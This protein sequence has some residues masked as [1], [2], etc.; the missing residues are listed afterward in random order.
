MQTAH[1]RAKVM[2]KIYFLV[3]YMPIWRCWSE[4][5][6]LEPS[7]VELTVM[8][9]S[10]RNLKSA[11]S[12]LLSRPPD[13]SKPPCRLPLLGQFIPCGAGKVLHPH[14]HIMA[15]KWI[16]FDN[17]ARCKICRLEHPRQRERAVMTKHVSVCACA[18]VCVFV[19]VGVCE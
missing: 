5:V 8:S 4:L 13:E 10:I 16:L 2:D 7:T 3:S 12:A 19:C 18:C 1:R 17:R 15:M 11:P 9:T 6:W 14:G